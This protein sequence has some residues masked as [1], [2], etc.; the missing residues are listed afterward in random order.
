MLL[1]AGE[2]MADPVAKKIPDGKKGFHGTAMH[3]VPELMVMHPL[4]WN[5]WQSLSV[6]VAVTWTFESLL[7]VGELGDILCNPEPEMENNVLSTESSIP[8]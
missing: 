6:I 7:K 3:T 4:N 8:R 5:F 2:V 1:Q